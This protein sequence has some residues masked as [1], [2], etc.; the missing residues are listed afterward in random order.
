M[1]Y[2]SEGGKYGY[3]NPPIWDI[4]WAKSDDQ[5]LFLFKCKSLLLDNFLQCIVP[6]QRTI[7]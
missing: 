1:K 3:A 2:F 6:L 4:F 5:P 7:V